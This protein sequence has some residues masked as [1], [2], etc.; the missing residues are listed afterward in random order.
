MCRVQK[1]IGRNRRE[2]MH[3]FRE[4]VGAWLLSH[5]LPKSCCD[6]K[7]A[8]LVLLVNG[9]CKFDRDHVRSK[10][11]NSLWPYHWDMLGASLES[12]SLGSLCWIFNY[13]SEDCAKRV[14]V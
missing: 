3:D 14:G 1:G 10:G 2:I 4:I 6:G 12:D 13:K 8:L 9:V 11:V 5:L 7:K